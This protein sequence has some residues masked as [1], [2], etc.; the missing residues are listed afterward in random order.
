MG[1]IKIRDGQQKEIDYVVDGL[2]GAGLVGKIAG[3]F[4]IEELEMKHYASVES[5]DLPPIAVYG[6]GYEVKPLVRVYL[7]PDS[8]I[9]VI[10]SDLPVSPGATDLFHALVSWFIAEEITPMYVLGQPIEDDGSRI[11]GIS[12]G[13]GDQILEDAEIPPPENPGAVMGAT[14]ALVHQAESRDLTSVGFIV[15]VDSFFPDPGAAQL[16][17]DQGVQTITGLE[18]DTK[19]L[20]DSEDIITKQKE[21]L[22]E[23]IKT[24]RNTEAGQAYP[25][26]MYR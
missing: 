9:G 14:G 7:D 6:N 15:D 12:T 22:A 18:L 13:N 25:T 10:T 4:L 17:I 11:Y 23:Q 5:S 20:M 24:V 16:T 2:P 8:R 19:P 1:R 3:E 21:R 26:E